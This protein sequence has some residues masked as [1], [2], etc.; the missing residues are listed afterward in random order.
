MIINERKNFDQE[1][2][3]PLRLIRTSRGL[4]LAYIEKRT[5]YPR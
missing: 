4:E 1:K 5:Y 3:S 2:V